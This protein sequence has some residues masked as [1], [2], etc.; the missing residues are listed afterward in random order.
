LSHLPKR[1]AD[2]TFAFQT[3]RQ[4]QRTIDGGALNKLDFPRLPPASPSIWRRR[5]A[6]GAFNNAATASPH[7]GGSSEFPQARDGAGGLDEEVE[8]PAGADG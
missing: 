6:T 1:S 3:G 5:V 2:D 8:H 4:P 7:S